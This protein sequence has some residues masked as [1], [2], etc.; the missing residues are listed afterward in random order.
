MISH[1]FQI[2]EIQLQ[3]LLLANPNMGKNSHVGNLAVKIVELFYLSRY[4][5]AVFVTG[6]KGADI[7]IFYD[8]K[9]EKFEVKGTADKNISWSKLKVSSQNCYECLVA[10]MTLIRV[11]GVGT[12]SPKLHFLKYGNDFILVHEVR[13]AVR[14]IKQ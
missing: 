10:G 4:P 8:G 13:Y 14:R 5:N 3:E 12:I 2:T 11:T 1:N 7:E 9:V 6:K